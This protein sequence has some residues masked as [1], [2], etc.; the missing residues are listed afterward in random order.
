MPVLLPE[1]GSTGLSIVLTKRKLEKG[2]L[3]GNNRDSYLDQGIHKRAFAAINRTV[4]IA[5]GFGDET[6]V[7]RR[8]LAR[9]CLRD[10]EIEHSF[11][12]GGRAFVNRRQAPA[13]EIG[14]STCPFVA[15][16]L[17]GTWGAGQEVLIIKLLEN[18]QV[19]VRRKIDYDID[20]GW[21]RS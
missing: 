12:E 3:S 15:C 17:S 18:I 4:D 11:T 8:Q 13:I 10:R 1:D 16:V 5:R 6:W 20:L 2:L 21:I 7:H 14:T 9:L 19:L